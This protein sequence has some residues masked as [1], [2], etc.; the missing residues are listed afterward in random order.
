MV[1]VLLIAIVGWGVPALLRGR[2]EARKASCGGN[3]KSI[4]LM[5]KMYAQAYND[6]WPYEE[7]KGNNARQNF[8]LL[9]RAT[10]GAPYETE[11]PRNIA[12]F[13]CPSSDTR[14][15]ITGTVPS[16][17]KYTDY[18]YID[19][20]PE[21]YLDKNLPLSV[22]IGDAWNGH[23]DPSNG[24]WTHAGGTTTAWGDGHK[25]WRENEYVG[26]AP[27]SSWPDVK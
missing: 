22:V 12:V 6:T 23:S 4:A 10:Y 21:S 3:L 26:I 8:Y 25:E 15:N 11:A 20:P 18:A 9:Y 16:D 5:C 19:G 13:F 17:F 27:G 24:K 7:S 1:I 14:E 2:E